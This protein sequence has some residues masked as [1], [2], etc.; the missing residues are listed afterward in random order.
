MTDING[1]NT[2]TTFTTGLTTDT[3]QDLSDTAH[4]TLTTDTID[5]VATNV[6]VNGSSIGLPTVL[7]H[8]LDL[9]TYD[10]TGP[11]GLSLTGINTKTQNLTALSANTT[12]QGKLT[13]N[14]TPVVLDN[15]LILSSAPLLT[16]NTPDPLGSIGMRFTITAPISIFRI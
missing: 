8:N 12:A 11:L 10:I 3:I 4:I 15:A 5:L 14:T 16:P 1:N 9:G 2:E 7:P 6:L 13:M